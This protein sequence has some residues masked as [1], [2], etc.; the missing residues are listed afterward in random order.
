MV[1][2]ATLLQVTKRLT[3]DA[4][5]NVTKTWY[6]MLRGNKESDIDYHGESYW[7]FDDG[8]KSFEIMDYRREDVMSIRYRKKDSAGIVWTYEFTVCFGGQVLSIR[9]SKT[10]KTG[11][12]EKHCR[13]NPP[14][15]LTLMDNN[16]YLIIDDNSNH[17]SPLYVMLM[18]G[19]VG[20]TKL[21]QIMRGQYISTLPV[22]YVSKTYT[23]GT[24]VNAQELS[25]K[26]AGMAHI[27]LQDEVKEINDFVLDCGAAN[28]EVYGDVGIYYP[29]NEL[30]HERFKRRKLQGNSKKLE[31]QIIDAITSYQI[32]RDIH[33]LMTWDG[34]AEAMRQNAEEEKSKALA[35]AVLEA[36]E[37]KQKAVEAA[38]AVSDEQIQKIRRKAV[39]DAQ[40]AGKAE[41]DGILAEFDN[42][43]RD[44]QK[45]L[46]E[47][48]DT[49]AKLQAENSWMKEK[50]EA[51]NKKPLIV[52]GEEKAVYPGEIKDFVLGAVADALEAAPEKTR[53]HDVLADILDANDYQ[54]TA[55]ERADK[56]LAVLTD[57]SGMTSALRSELQKLGFEI[58]S[59]NGH[60]KLLYGGDA[61]Y[62]IIV[63]KTPSDV[64]TGVNCAKTITRNIF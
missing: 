29:K 61:R 12:L 2:Y 56:V 45:A 62:M 11:R 60:Y 26:L 43:L 52:S 55:K 54:D 10:Q 47:R 3:R 38:A 14:R 50:L 39:E 44:K 7:N 1:I 28:V 35:K 4:F 63:S 40:A 5:V 20:G 37:A 9:I 8:K 42:E 22:V 25:A 53:R 33:P 64:S 41:A 31:K 27:A 16:G 57:Y 13:A 32:T 6:G 18:H 51:V 59:E 15:I 46:Q 58:V 30:P 34:I 49:I 23:G 21:M 36:D 48:D 19:A 17:L 24:L